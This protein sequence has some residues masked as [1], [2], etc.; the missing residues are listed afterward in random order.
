MSITRPRY[1]MPEFV[2]EKQLNQ[3]LDEL[4]GSGLYLHM[5]MKWSEKV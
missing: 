1:E 5:K 4:T 3:M 2:R